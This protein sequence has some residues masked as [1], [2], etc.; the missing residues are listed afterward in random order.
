LPGKG[1]FMSEKP[2]AI[3]VISLRERER[4]VALMRSL[5]YRILLFNSHIDIEDALVVD[6]PVEVDLNDEERVL[7]SARQLA[8]RFSIEGVYTLNEYRVPLVARLAAALNLPYGLSYEAALNC[9][10]KKY[11]RER[12]QLWGVPSARFTLIR[13]PQEA[14]AALTEFSLP[15][16]IKPSNESASYLVSCCATPEEVYQA[17]EAIL[18]CGG[19]NWVGQDSDPEILLEEYL[20]GPEVSVEACT[21][22][23]QTKVL[24]ITAKQLTAPP[25][26]VEVGHTVPAPLSASVV[27]EIHRVVTAT[28]MALRVDWAVT[29]TE[30]RL[31]STGPRIIEVNIRPGGDQIVDL[32]RAVTGYDLLEIAIHVA[33]GR[34]L[35]T[36]KQHTTQAPTAAIRFLAAEQA[37]TVQINNPEE[38][39]NWPGVQ[40]IQLEVSSGDVVERTVSNY[41]RLGHVLVWGNSSHTADQ[42][43]EEVLEHLA[44]RIHPDIS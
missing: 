22:A 2:Q 43:A 31:T 26:T 38:I 10:H 7:A 27:E 4:Q 9:R 44:M 28:L 5:G 30:V 14:L 25:L 36:I 18:Q 34:S 19:K 12:L 24:A 13:T 3:I 39:A 33:L 17:V 35:E 1:S 40:E 15:V 20:D 16:V 41:H 42:I 29:H 6:V 8:E 37:G 21:A 23:G 32:V 11:T